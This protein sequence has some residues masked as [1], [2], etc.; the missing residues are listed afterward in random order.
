[1]TRAPARQDLL[2]LLK[3]KNVLVMARKQTRASNAL[4]AGEITVIYQHICADSGRLRDIC[5]KHRHRTRT[6]SINAA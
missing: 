6:G 1:M 3:G 2:R 4:E 5:E